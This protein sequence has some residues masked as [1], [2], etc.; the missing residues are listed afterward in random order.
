[1]KQTKKRVELRLIDNDGISGYKLSNIRKVLGKKVCPRFRGW[2][3]GQTVMKY[4][5][6]IFI[7]K[8]DLI[9]FLNGE[10]V[11]VGENTKYYSNND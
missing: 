1:M 9:R 6:D 4:K 3:G 8:H 7:Y 2:I 11:M 10:P 5:G